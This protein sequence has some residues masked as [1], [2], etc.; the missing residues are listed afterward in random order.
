M[1]HA[2]NLTLIFCFHRNTVAV[3]PHGNH[4]ILQVTPV[5]A[6]YHAGKLRVD[7]IAGK[8][9]GTSYMFQPWACIICNF[10][11]RENTAI[12]FGTKRSKGL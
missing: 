6:V 7:L 10:F 4:R 1:H 8:R 3:V 2:G 11:L 12:D 9:N 5:R